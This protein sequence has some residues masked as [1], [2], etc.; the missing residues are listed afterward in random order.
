MQGHIDDIKPIFSKKL[1]GLLREYLF[2]GGMPEVVADF[3]EH[4]DFTEARR[5]Q[6]AILNDYNRD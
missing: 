3:S 1:T 2:V 5:L 6:Q 4:H